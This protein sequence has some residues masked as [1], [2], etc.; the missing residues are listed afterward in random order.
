MGGIVGQIGNKW[1]IKGIL[2]Q[3]LSGYPVILLML[4]NPADKWSLAESGENWPLFVN[5]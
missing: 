4:Y 3:N 1:K 5:K 2:N